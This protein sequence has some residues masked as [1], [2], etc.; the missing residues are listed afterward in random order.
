MSHSQSCVKLNNI[1]AAR[2]LLDTMYTTLDAD[3]VARIVEMNAPPLPNKT[4]PARF[5]FTVKIV[6][7]ENLVGADGSTRSKVDPYLILSDSEGHRVAKTRTLYQ[8]N[9]PRWDETTDVSVQGDRWLRATVY[10]R[11]LVE[12]HDW[13][14]SAFIHLNPNEYGDFL[15]RDV[16]LQ[17][18]DSNRQVMD[19]RL[20]LRISM[21]G[22][23]DDIQFYFGR[24][25][26]SLKRAENDMTRTMV[27]VVSLDPLVDPRERFLTMSTDAA[28]RSQLPLSQHAQGSHQ[29][30]VQL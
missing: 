16:W 13:V 27:D 4:G 21:E 17:L 22:E 28:V 26:R 25:F 23:K 15:A 11:N 24:A 12:H 20:L 2:K 9:D 8:T 19:S 10:H 3:K 5:L 18:E 14:A 6:L 7:A 29:D 1:Q 30:V